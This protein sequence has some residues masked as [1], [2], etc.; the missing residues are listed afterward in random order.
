MLWASTGYQMQVIGTT[1]D[2]VRKAID[3]QENDRASFQIDDA[4]NVGAKI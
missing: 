2:S 3:L 1:N 4:L